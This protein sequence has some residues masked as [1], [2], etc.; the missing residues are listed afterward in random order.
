[1]PKLLR[2][3]SRLKGESRYSCQGPAYAWPSAAASGRFALGQALG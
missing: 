2:A 1:M 3:G